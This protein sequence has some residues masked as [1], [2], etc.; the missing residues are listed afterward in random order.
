[1]DSKAKKL[2]PMVVLRYIAVLSR[3]QPIIR[4]PTTPDNKQEPP[5]IDIYVG[6]YLNGFKRLLMVP[7][8][9]Q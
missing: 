7:P 9:P 6:E 1:M 8:T 5:A 4:A 3:K 2:I